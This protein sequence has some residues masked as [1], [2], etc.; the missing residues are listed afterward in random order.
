[1]S[2]W[3]LLLALFVALNL[4]QSAFSNTCP[5]IWFLRKMGFKRCVNP[6]AAKGGG[7]G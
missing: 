5:A 3:W 6:D 1:V 2:R 7:N 4:L